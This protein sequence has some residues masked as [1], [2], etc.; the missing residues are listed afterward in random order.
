MNYNYN[1]NYYGNPYTRNF[2][3]PNYGQTQYQQPIVQPSSQQQ[4]QQPMQMQYEAPIQNVGYATLKEAE[5]FIVYPNSKALFIDKNKGMSYLKVANNDGQSFIRYFKQVEVSA[6]GKP[7]E[8]TKD[9]K[10]VDL[11]TYATKT[12]LEQFASLKQYNE[13]LGKIEQLQK[14]IVGGRIN[15]TPNNGKNN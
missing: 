8:S 10:S 3:Q 15:G 4:M 9:T 11:S 14:Q 5:A 2:P 12:D 7:L 13:L 6:D 1:P